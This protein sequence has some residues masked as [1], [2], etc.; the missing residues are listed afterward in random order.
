MC[1]VLSN[2]EEQNIFYLSRSSLS[3]VLSFLRAKTTYCTFN[4]KE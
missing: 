3:I 1:K 2:I 4:Q